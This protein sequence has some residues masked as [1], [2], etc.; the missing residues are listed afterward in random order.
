M[1][2]FKDLNLSFY[3]NLRR[4]AT[5]HKKVKGNQNPQNNMF[6]SFCFASTAHV[7][8][9]S[10][11]LTQRAEILTRQSKLTLQR[12]KNTVNDLFGGTEVAFVIKQVFFTPSSLFSLKPASCSRRLILG[13]E[14]FLPN[15]SLLL[16]TLRKKWSRTWSISQHLHSRA[17]NL[18]I[19]IV[20]MVSWND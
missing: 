17:I 14:V 4:H 5:W 18:Y 9:W 16:N 1:R 13:M 3:R 20:L 19:Y 6:A 12:A 15:T 11:Y 2:R 10:N 8:Q 7:T